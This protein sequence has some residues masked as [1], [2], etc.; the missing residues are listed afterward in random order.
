VLLSIVRRH[1]DEA[2]LGLG[3]YAASAATGLR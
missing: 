2:S 1:M 3:P